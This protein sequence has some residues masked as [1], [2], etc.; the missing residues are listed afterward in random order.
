MSDIDSD[1]QL[2]GNN[3]CGDVYYSAERDIS[4]FEDLQTGTSRWYAWHGDFD[5]HDQAEHSPV[6]DS[7]DVAIGPRVED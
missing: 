5:V 4:L 1:F 3:E 2:V 6:C 7:P